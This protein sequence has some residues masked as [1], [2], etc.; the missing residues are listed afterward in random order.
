M[1]MGAPS[2][3]RASG[4]WRAE[5]GE[6]EPVGDDAHFPT[7]GDEPVSQGGDSSLHL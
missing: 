5:V 3:V 1:V 6:M 2:L 4:A 7:W